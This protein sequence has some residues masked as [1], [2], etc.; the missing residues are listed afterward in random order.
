MCSVLQ[1]YMKEAVDHERYL[2]VRCDGADHVVLRIAGENVGNRW[3]V[4]RA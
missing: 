2:V 3:T 4:A 1:R